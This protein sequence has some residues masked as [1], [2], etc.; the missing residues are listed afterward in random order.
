MMRYFVSRCCLELQ[1]N[2]PRRLNRKVIGPF[3]CCVDEKRLQTWGQWVF[4]LEAMACG[5]ADH[6]HL[7]ISVSNG[8]QLPYHNRISIVNVGQMGRPHADILA[9]GYKLCAPTFMNMAETMHQRLWPRSSYGLEKIWAACP[10]TRMS[11]IHNA[12]WWTVGHHHIDVVDRALVMVSERKIMSVIGV[13]LKAPV[14]KCGCVWA[15][16]D[17]QQCTILQ[18]KGVDTFIKE[19]DTSIIEQL[20]GLP[21]IFIGLFYELGIQGWVRFIHHLSKCRDVQREVVI[22]G[23][24]QFKGSVK[25]LETAD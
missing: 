5:G 6:G 23:D 3:D 7:P 20:P 16:I 18:T 17:S 15:S 21:V 2:Q 4:I 1:I 11:V 10:L 25:F 8:G 19:S 14:A 22:A 24:D 13:I 12:L 9:P